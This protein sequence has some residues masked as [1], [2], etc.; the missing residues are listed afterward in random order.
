[1]D[2][3]ELEQKVQEMEKELN[4]LRPLKDSSVKLQGEF[5]QKEETWQK[6]KA[7]LEQQSNPNWKAM[8]ERD[9]RLV[10]AL[11]DKGLKVDEAGNVIG[12]PPGVDIEK[13]RLEAAQAARQELIGQ[14]LES[15]LG[16]YSDA[17]AKVVKHY[18]DKLTIGESVTTQNIKSFIKQA[19]GAAESETGNEIKRVAVSFSGGRG[20]RESTTEVSQENVN[21]LGDLMGLQFRQTKK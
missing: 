1:M 8:R 15:L 17:D 2:E 5:K 4:E 20:P 10:K 19:H 12:A 6:E 16:E 18:F 21:A 11:E 9:A 13:I 3:Q 7:E 14:Q